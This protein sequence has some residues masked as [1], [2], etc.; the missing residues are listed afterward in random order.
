LDPRIRKTYSPGSTTSTSLPASKKSYI[1]EHNREYN[2]QEYWEKRFADEE[3]YDWLAEYEHVRHLIHKYLPDRKARVLIVGCGNSRFSAQLY[4]DGYREL[5]N[6][7]YSAAVIERMR[8]RHPEMRWIVS[9]MTRLD[10]LPRTPEQ[11]SHLGLFDAVID[12]AAMDALMTEEG[13]VWDPRAEVRDQVDRMCSGISGVLHAE[14]G[15]FL[16]ISFAQTHFRSRYLLGAK[17]R[18]L[19]DPESG[20]TRQFSDSYSWY[21][22]HETFQPEGGCFHKFF[23]VCARGLP[24]GEERISEESFARGA[25]RV[26]SESESDEEGSWLLDI[27][28]DE[29]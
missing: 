1:A 15:L 13:D 20:L 16:Q 8:A 9:D 14:H 4:A 18:Q 29:Q 10:L 2:R 26:H 23:Y 11:A 5:T 28:T 19:V 27:Q 17:H 22:S 6:L 7:D 25:A 12:K 3:E 24:S 21:Y